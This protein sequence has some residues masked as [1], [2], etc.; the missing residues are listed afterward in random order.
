[1][2]GTTACLTMADKNITKHNFYCNKYDTTA[3]NDHGA[4][5]RSKNFSHKHHGGSRENLYHLRKTNSRDTC[6]GRLERAE[7]ERPQFSKR[8]ISL[9][10]NCN[11]KLIKHML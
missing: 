8:R 3:W 4:N 11:R 9:I 1:M 5:P 10:T 2:G 7:A 6:Q